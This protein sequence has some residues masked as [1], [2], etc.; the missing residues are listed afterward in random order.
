MD[1]LEKINFGK[2]IFDYEEIMEAI[3]SHSD[4]IDSDLQRVLKCVTR[5]GEN[6]LVYQILAT[7]DN[8]RDSLEILTSESYFIAH[9]LRKELKKNEQRQL[10]RDTSKNQSENG[11][12][13]QHGDSS[14]GDR[15]L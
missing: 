11:E 3:K 6:D 12:L 1:S 4:L 7:V 13:Q 8:I 14:K 15:N 5:L 9:R 10:A 2:K